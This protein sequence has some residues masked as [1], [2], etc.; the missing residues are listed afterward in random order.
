M[1][2]TYHFCGGCNPLFDRNQVYL[3][4][5][6]SLNLL[7]GP[8]GEAHGPEAENFASQGSLEVVIDGCHRQCLRLSDQYPG[9]L[10]V[11]QAMSRDFSDPAA[12]VL[13][14]LEEA[15]AIRPTMLT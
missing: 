12:A 1:N 3:A 2:I 7:E 10:L 4:L 5:K 8:A 14:L 13:L 6:E 15:K 11:F 9:A